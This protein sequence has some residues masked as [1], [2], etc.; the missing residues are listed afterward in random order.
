MS[1]LAGSTPIG[2]LKVVLDSYW[3]P[4]RH[5]ERLLSS[6]WTGSRLFSRGLMVYAQ[7]KLAEEGYRGR[8]VFIVLSNTLSN[9]HRDIPNYRTLSH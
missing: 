5:P 2:C 8:M 9:N 3:R 6:D 1:T 4:F 7:G